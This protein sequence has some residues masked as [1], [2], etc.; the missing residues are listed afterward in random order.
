MQ[1]VEVH[2]CTKEKYASLLEENVYL[3]KVHLLKE[4]GIKDLILRLQKEK[5]DYVVDLHNNLRTF[6]IKKRLRVKSYTFNK[7]NWKKWLMVNL[8]IN[9]LPNV[10]I[11]D[12]YLEAVK[13]LGIK[14]DALGLDYFI[15]EKDEVERKW[16]PETHRNGF[17]AVAIGA[18]H[19]TKKLPLKRLIELCDKIN[20]PVV[21]LGD[22]ND[23]VVGDLIEEFFHKTDDRNT[24]ESLLELNKKTIIFNACGKL[25]INQSASII[26]QANAVFTHDTGLM[27][28]AAAFKKNIFSIW[29]NTIPEFGMYPYRTSFTIFEK[30]GLSCRPCSKIGHKKCPKGHFLCMNKINFDFYLP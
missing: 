30:K 17:V 18:Q 10:H 13:P 22:S 8:K 2:Y 14:N 29:G 11:V 16:L 5:F 12:R 24:E 21:L 28:I 9:L 23:K 1:D 27:H 15:P 6:Y 7:L 19:S 4:I 20:K 3:D 26:K 25:S